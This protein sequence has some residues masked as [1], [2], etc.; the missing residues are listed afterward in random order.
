MDPGEYEDFIFELPSETTGD[1]RS[2]E[3]NQY[4]DNH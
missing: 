2:Q 1:T 4:L 3:M